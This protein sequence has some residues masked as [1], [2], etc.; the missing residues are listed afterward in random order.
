MTRKEAIRFLSNSPYK[1][2]HMLGFRDLNELNNKW[3][4]EMI[5]GTKDHTLQAHRLSYKTTCVSLALA[6]QMVLFPNKRIMFMRKTENDVKEVVAQVKKIL[7]SPH[8]TVF[9]KAIYGVNLELTSSNATE[10]TT[11]LQCDI[12]GTSQLVAVGCGG[13][14]TGKHFDRIFTD[15]IVNVQDRISKAERER[16]KLIYQELKNIV[17][18]DGKIFNTGTPWHRDDCFTIMPP[19]E[20]YDCYT[21]GIMTAENISEQ[22][23]SM[24]SALFAAN[25]ELKHIAD[26][27]ALFT[28]PR[29]NADASKIE[30]GNCHIDAAYGGGDGT[31]FTIVNK[32]G[33][34]YFVLGKL[35]NKHVDN[36]LCDVIALRSKYM[37][38][39]I[40]CE[41]NGDKGYLAKELRNRG[42]RVKKYH[43]TTNK[44]IKISSYLKPIWD[45]VYFVEGT[46][47][48][49]INQ[50]CDY[51]ENA[52]HDDAPDS[53]VSLIRNLYFKKEADTYVSPFDR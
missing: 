4:V 22:K 12:K 39:A 2:G 21:T 3:I 49:Y 30:Q 41:D 28:E 15:D 16:T 29:I 44:Y 11:N 31:A 45:H 40:Y 8:M 53:L 25:Y 1:L 9:V 34:D 43:E 10:I 46:D 27:D 38:G 50:V 24:T 23:A 32:I 51:N 26:E 36:C 35:W 17:M 6:I 47:S 14:L 13:S 5:K 19:A 7:Q 33:D 37:C 42:E 48:E 18:R 20:K 52:E